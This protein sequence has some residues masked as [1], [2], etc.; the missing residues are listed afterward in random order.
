MWVVNATEVTPLP[1]NGALMGSNGLP[2][3]LGNLLEF[4]LVLD[5]PVSPSGVTDPFTRQCTFVI[6]TSSGMSV[7]SSV[8]SE[9]ILHQFSEKSIIGFTWP[10]P[11]NGIT[12][13]C[14]MAISLSL[15]LSPS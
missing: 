4:L 1:N 15:S 10:C 14:V 8:L 3:W 12:R 2:V 13:T 11:G 9:T 7:C 6:V 5:D